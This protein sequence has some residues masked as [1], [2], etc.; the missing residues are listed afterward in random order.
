MAQWWWLNRLDHSEITDTLGEK[1]N[2]N[3]TNLKD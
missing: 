3:M 2:Q 1:N